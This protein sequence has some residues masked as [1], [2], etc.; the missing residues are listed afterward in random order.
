M[1]VLFV[2][3]EQA[4]VCVFGCVADVVVVFGRG[5]V[6]CV[7]CRVDH[8]AL[9]VNVERGRVFVGA[10]SIL[11]ERAWEGGVSTLGVVVLGISI[12]ADLRAVMLMVSGLTPLHSDKS[13]SYDSL[14]Y[15]VN[16]LSL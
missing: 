5:C 15:T 14:V 3:A 10:N 1:L 6:L 4:D 2:D 13:F 12:F 9:N 16:M 8:G 11:E 7:V